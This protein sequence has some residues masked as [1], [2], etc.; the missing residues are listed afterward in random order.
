[1]VEEPTWTVDPLTDKWQAW[2][3]KH[4]K[5]YGADEGWYRFKTFKA[6]DALIEAHNSLLGTKF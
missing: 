5:K 1:M 6:N 2:K 3:A 4:G